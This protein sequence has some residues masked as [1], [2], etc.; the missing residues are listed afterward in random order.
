[1]NDLKDKITDATKNIMDA[2]DKLAHDMKT[3]N[4]EVK[5]KL[6]A[7]NDKAKGKFNQAKGA[8]KTKIGNLTDNNKLKAE[9]LV[10]TVIGKTQEISGNIKETVND[11][12]HK[13]TK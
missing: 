7:M 4:S 1:M 13:H 8:V 5:G 9:G 3:N 2:E 11:A 12:T 10:D 6:D